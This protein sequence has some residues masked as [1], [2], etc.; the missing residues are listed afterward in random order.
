MLVKNSL[1]NIFDGQ[2]VRVAV[3]IGTLAF[4]GSL[5]A[6]SGNGVEVKP[7]GLLDVD[8]AL[9]VRYLRDDN[10]R[11][12]GSGS[13]TSEYGIIWSESLRINTTSYVY[14]PA[15]LNIDFDFGPTFLQQQFNTSSE[16]EDLKQSLLDYSARLNFLDRKRYPFSIFANRSH[17]KVTTGL[18]GRIITPTDRYGLNW[19]LSSPKNKIGVHLDIVHEDSNGSGFGS[20]IDEDVDRRSI[21]IEKSF[22]GNGLLS[23]DHSFL[24]RKSA[25]GSLGLP[26]SE[27]RIR[28]QSTLVNARNAF[29]ANDQLSIN[30][31]L[32][33]LKQDNEA[34]ASSEVVDY[35]YSGSAILR[36][37]DSLSSF[38]NLLMTKTDRAESDLRNFDFSGGVQ[39]RLS[40]YASYGISFD[41][42]E[43]NKS[44]FEQGR[45]GARGSINYSRKVR[46]GSVSLGG[47]VRNA[48]T[49]QRSAVDTVGVFDEPVVLNDTTPA[50]L[51][52]EFVVDNS[53][54][55]S[56][57]AQTQVYV[58]GLD[59]RLIRIGT[60]T[61]IQRLVP[62]NIFDGETVLVD[63]E[64]EASGTAEY[65]TLSAGLNGGVTFLKYFNA[66]MSLSDSRTN[67]SSGALN[68]PTNDQRRIEFNV[69]ADIPTDTGWNLGGYFRYT[70][71]DEEISPQVGSQ[72]ELRA[73]TDVFG[74]MALSL[75][76]GLTQLDNQQSTED[77][78]GISYRLGLSGRL[79]RGLRMRYDGSYISDSGGS[80]PRKRLQHRFDTFWNYR[81]LQFAFR[82][83]YWEDTLGD[84]K[85][86]STR[87]M[88]EL[89][90]FF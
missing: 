54:V 48:R 35:R 52:N 77:V 29:G 47:F 55:V 5:L 71:V 40:D 21:K 76:G 4:S 56:N 59:Y 50:E 66:R 87:V 22:A 18:S 58:E 45:V 75:A 46:F 16:E 27:S 9:E 34:V 86:N 72:L 64:Y 43:S 41:V 32:N 2:Y 57:I 88:A 10:E 90:R 79:W 51:I 26:I 62:S 53:V 85:N 28:Q 67:I 73:S 11:L 69:G 39:H 70:D 60:V 82:A 23:I 38:A 65:E 78:N 25:S 15:F 6:N 24:D 61:S 14:H 33:R 30:H 3:L 89:T 63:Y 12:S 49:D 36:Y 13:D 81:Q 84:S 42:G 68:Q 31:S 17:P 80:L 37:S 44:G 74:F 20:V 19:R 7:F 83:V 8:Y 1:P